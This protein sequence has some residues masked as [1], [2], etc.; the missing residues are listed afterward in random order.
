MKRYY[1]I[2]L[3]SLLAA[4]FLYAFYRTGNTVVNRLFS[5]VFGT[6]GFEAL[7]VAITTT[8]PL[9]NFII[10]SLPEALW[11]FAATLLSKNLFFGIGR[12]PVRCVYFPLAFAYIWELNQLFGLTN[13]RFDAWD[14]LSCT[15][16]FLLARDYFRAPYGHTHILRH[17]SWQGA[18]FFTGFG[19]VYL[20]HVVL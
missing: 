1:S 6:E 10:Y 7:R 16:A 17:F 19:I 9:P 3:L 11:V 15:A 5:A 12:Y 20:S 14:M 13:G 2:I 18:L 4:L 8:L